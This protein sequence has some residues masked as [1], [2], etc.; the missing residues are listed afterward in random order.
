MTDGAAPV[1]LYLNRQ[2]SDV[3]ATLNDLKIEASFRQPRVL[4][5]QHMAP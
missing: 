4:S 3:D 1:L 5:T 2:Y